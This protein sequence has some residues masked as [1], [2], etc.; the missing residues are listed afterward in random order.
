MC[1]ALLHD[2][3]YQMF[4]ETQKGGHGMGDLSRIANN[5]LWT[6]DSVAVFLMVFTI[7]MA[8]V[9]PMITAALVRKYSN[10]EFS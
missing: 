4:Y 8:I 7:A 3:E 9:V 6:Q 5:H 2:V 10:P 1:N